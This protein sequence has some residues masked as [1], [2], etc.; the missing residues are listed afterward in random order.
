MEQGIG[1]SI[2]SGGESSFESCYSFKTYHSIS[3]A[4]INQTY[5]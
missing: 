4:H 3:I 2:N 5:Q 1:G